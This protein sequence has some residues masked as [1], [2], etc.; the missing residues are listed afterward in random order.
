MHERLAT[1]A[2]DGHWYRRAYFDDGTPLGSSTSDECR[3]DAIAQSW[4]VISGAGDPARRRQA[5]ASF[6]EHL[7]REDA[8]LLMLLTPPFDETPN[9]P[10]YIK[11]YLPGVR[12]NG[13]QY[14]HGVLWAIRA[15]AE[16]GHGTRATELL[17]MISP[18][19]HTR[20]KEKADHYKTEPYAIAAD[21]Y[22]VPPHAGRGGWTWYTGSAGWTYRVAVE[23]I[24]GLKVTAEALVL[25]PRIPADWRGFSL[26]YRLP[27]DGTL[28]VFTVENEGVEHGV[29]A[30]DGAG[31]T[32]QDGAAHVPLVRDGGTHAVT[33]RLGRAPTNGSPSPAE[34]SASSHPSGSSGTT[35]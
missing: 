31:G 25:D 14:T 21:V 1:S 26:R 7:V 6:E 9:D 15:F 11:G 17:R 4:S 12:E 33:V 19:N 27:E 29:V 13:G 3:I 28:Y 5:M 10:G 30:V 2:W 35:S 23:S 8:R 22:S 20:T 18:V 32:V 24:L 16:R 34:A